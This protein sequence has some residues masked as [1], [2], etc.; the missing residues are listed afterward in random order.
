MLDVFFIPNSFH[1]RTYDQNTQIYKINNF[2]TLRQFYLERNMMYSVFKL[3][4]L[5][6]STNFLFSYFEKTIHQNADCVRGM[7]RINSVW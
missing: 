6:I 4:F 3:S 1:K 2:L 7:E 5:A